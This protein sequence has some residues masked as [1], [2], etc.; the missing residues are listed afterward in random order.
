MI[1]IDKD[2]D[3]TSF[4][5]KSRFDE[6]SKLFAIK[7][8]TGEYVKQNHYKTFTKFLNNAQLYRRLE[9]A[10]EKAKMAAQVLEESSKQPVKLYV[11]EVKIIEKE[12]ICT[13]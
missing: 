13:N 7:S 6:E 9:T 5:D 10:M 11:V 8:E 2:T 3:I 1:E 12:C 4:L